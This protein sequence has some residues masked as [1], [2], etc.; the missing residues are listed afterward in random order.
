MV[1]GRAVDTRGPDPKNAG[2]S[3]AVGMI[4]VGTPSRRI[5]WLS[6]PRMARCLVSRL[7]LRGCSVVG[8][9][10]CR[11]TNPGGLGVRTATAGRRM[12]LAGSGVVA[13]TGDE[14]EEKGLRRQEVG[15]LPSHLQKN[16]VPAP[17]SRLG[18]AQLVP[19]SE[20]SP[21]QTVA[22]CLA[23]PGQWQSVCWRGARV[24]SKMD[25]KTRNWEARL[26]KAGWYHERRGV[27][28]FVSTTKCSA[29]PFRDSY[30]GC[31]P[32]LFPRAVARLVCCRI[33]DPP[34]AIS[35]EERPLCAALQRA[36]K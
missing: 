13:G 2:R 14:E 20:R 32:L 28:G 19:A 33:A 30:L 25:Q 12:G 7:R 24:A 34:T 23:W 36:Q 3:H 18:L 31:A 29:D 9:G 8:S 11:R 22:E 1:V 35:A 21:H 17:W 16:I 6:R 26:S 5:R 27:V 4:G 15:V 10:V